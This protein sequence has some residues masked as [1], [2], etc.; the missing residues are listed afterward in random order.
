[1]YVK[2][3]ILSYVMTYTHFSQN[4]NLFLLLEIIWYF[5][6]TGFYWLANK[7]KELTFFQDI[8]LNSRN[9]WLKMIISRVTRALRRFFSSLWG[10]STAPLLSIHKNRF[11]LSIKQYRKLKHE[12]LKCFIKQFI[13]YYPLTFNHHKRF[14]FFL[15]KFC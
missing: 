8:T 5:L 4:I 9:L 7:R 14:I 6:A 10:F 2:L 11:F 12:I 13:V 3:Y 15:I 1:M